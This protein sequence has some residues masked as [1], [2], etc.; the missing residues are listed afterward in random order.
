MKRVKKALADKKLVIVTGAGVTLDATGYVPGGELERL[1]WKGLVEHGFRYLERKCNPAISD[2]R[3]T[4]ER[5]Q[6]INNGRYFLSQ[7]ETESHLLA[8]QILRKEL[9]DEGRF[10]AWLDSVFDDLPIKNK[11]LLDALQALHE[12]GATL[13]TTNYDHLLDRYCRLETIHRSA[14]NDLLRFRRGRAFKDGVFH[15]HGSYQNPDDVILDPIDYYKVKVSPEVQD[16]LRKC[17]QDDLVLFVGCGGG[18]GDANFSA[19]LG[20]ITD[21]HR[22]I[23]H[24]H[25]L[26]VTNNDSYNFNPLVRLKYGANHGDLSSWLWDKLLGAP[27]GGDY[28]SGGPVQRPSEETTASATNIESPPHDVIPEV[29][30]SQSNSSPVYPPPKIIVSPTVA[31]RSAKALITAAADGNMK[32][33]IR[34]SDMVRDFN[35]LGGRDEDTTALQAA[36]QNGHMDV[37]RELLARGADPSVSGWYYPAPLTM[38]IQKDNAELVNLLL[39]KGAKAD[40]S[41]GASGQWV[42][43][44]L[45][46][47]IGS[48]K[49]DMALLLLSQGADPNFQGDINALFSIQTAVKTNNARAVEYLAEHKANLNNRNIMTGTALIMA[50]EANNEGLV[51][52]LLDKGANIHAA[53]Y[54][55]NGTPLNTA[56]RFDNNH[57]AKLLLDRGAD[58][59]VQGDDDALFPLQTAVHRNN[60]EAVAFLLEKRARTDLQM[61]LWPLPIDI[62]VKNGNDEIMMMLL[63]HE[64]PK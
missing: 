9:E 63:E 47:A 56:L 59:N 14:T 29:Y 30:V 5:N 15:I 10:A 46:I 36:I 44:A 39:E 60:K 35:M 13:L 11:A 1:K 51:N 31:E 20:W 19:L 23:A 34:L 24:T 28:T 2:Q 6:R 57:L 16:F 21:K 61:I 55:S 7:S 8:A 3:K 43:C 41:A 26:L 42:G 22:A 52:L 45:N 25:C 32:M 37:V 62:A 17:L 50:I 48:G 53:G 40:A 64:T 4:L 27:S 38:A 49:D 58:P 54:G 33:V 12:N 18:L